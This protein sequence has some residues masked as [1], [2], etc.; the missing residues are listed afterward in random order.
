ML[1]IL[2]TNYPNYPALTESGE[3]NTDYMYDDGGI[4]WFAVITLGLFNKRDI[5]GFDSRELYDPQ[6]VKAPVASRTE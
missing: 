6:Y 4:N 1:E 3:F 5:T 2:R